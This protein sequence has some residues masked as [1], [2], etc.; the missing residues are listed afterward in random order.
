[1]AEQAGQALQQQLP[2]LWELATA[3]V[4]ALAAQQPGAP[5][6]L[7]AAVQAL[8][9]LGVLAPAVHVGLAPQLEALLPAV[10][11]C[12]QQPN[13][14]LKLAA[15]R[16]M[17]SLAAA[18]TQALMPALLRALSPMLAGAWLGAGA[19]G[20]QRMESRH[21]SAVVAVR[22]HPPHSL[23]PA[24]AP[25]TRPEPAL[26]CAGGAP[27]DARLGAL[28]ALHHAVQRLGLGLVRWAGALAGKRGAAGLI[29]CRRRS[30]PLLPLR[31]LPAHLPPRPG[32]HATRR[33]PI[34]C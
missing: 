30:P 22:E 15:A 23:Q 13:A 2:K 33:C 14:A 28:L 1:M 16:C 20:Q 21:A 7:Q 31:P 26:R 6:D 12:L 19:L 34:A 3:P 18:H 32:P 4:A 5:V 9:V 11:A 29:R 17:A 10:A 27:D 8:H 24:C 25:D